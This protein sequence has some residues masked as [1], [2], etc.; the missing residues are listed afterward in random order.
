MRKL[1]VLFALAAFAMPAAVQKKFCEDLKSEI[2]AELKANGDAKYAL[3]IVP[4]GEAKG[5]MEV[6][7]GG[8]AK[9]IIYKRS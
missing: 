1:I 5:A 9:G 8:V 6:G 2:L 7:S 3:N 4:A